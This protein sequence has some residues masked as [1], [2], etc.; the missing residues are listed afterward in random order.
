MTPEG[1]RTNTTFFRYV[2]GHRSA[3]IPAALLGVARRGRKGICTDTRRD[4]G[5]LSARWVGIAASREALLA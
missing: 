5:P 2:N 4:F 3:S 1:S